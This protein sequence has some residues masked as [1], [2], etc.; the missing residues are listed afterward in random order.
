MLDNYIIKE[1]TKKKYTYKW[2]VGV[3]YVWIG[4]N[5]EF[6]SKLRT[7]NHLLFDVNHYPEWNYDGSSTDQASGEYLW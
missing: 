4:G 6:R 5:G 2:E 3:Y 1:F 7:V